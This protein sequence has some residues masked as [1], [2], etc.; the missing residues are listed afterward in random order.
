MSA[1]SPPGGKVEPVKL[2]I[3]KW[4]IPKDPPLG[5]PALFLGRDKQTY[6]E[7]GT[8]WEEYVPEYECGGIYGKTAPDYQCPYTL[9]DSVHQHQIGVD[10]NRRDAGSDTPNKE[11]RRMHVMIASYRDPLCP[12]TLFNL[13][14]KAAYPELVHVTVLQQNDPEVDLDCLK[15]YCEMIQEHK[16]A[17]DEDI[18]PKLNAMLILIMDFVSTPH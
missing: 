6:G 3:K 8:G 5:I 15:R 7:A 11:D 2:N 14:T 16:D 13:F 9:K 12:I 4:D 18:E 17:A 1:T 10:L